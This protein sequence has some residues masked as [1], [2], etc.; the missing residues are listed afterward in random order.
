M[1][2]ETRLGI[3]DSSVCVMMLNF[4][5]RALL[6]L[7]SLTAHVGDPGF[8]L[9]I[10]KVSRSTRCSYH[11]GT[12]CVAHW[13][14]ARG[15]T[16]RLSSSNSKSNSNSSSC[17]SR[18]SHGRGGPRAVAMTLDCSSP[19]DVSIAWMDSGILSA[20][21]HQPKHSSTAPCSPGHFQQ[22]SRSTG[23]NQERIS[24]R[25]KGGGV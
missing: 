6:A 23:I 15:L 10:G 25:G 21:Q 19:T 4:N 9:L 12:G 11:F 13:P 18:G 2:A 3:G 1:D 8:A 17:S 14:T 20:T 7:C 22:A 5:R 24:R 16:L